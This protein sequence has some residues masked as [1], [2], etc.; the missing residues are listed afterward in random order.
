MNSALAAVLSPTD[1]VA[2]AAIT[3]RVA[4]PRRIL[5]VL[6]GESLLNDASGL[7]CFQFAVAAALTGSLMGA[8]LQ[9]PAVLIAVAAVLIV[10]ATSLFGLWELRL[11]GGL[12]QAAAKSYSGYFGSLF[13]G[14]T[15]G[16]VAAPCIG[17]FVL[18]L[19]FL[20][21]E[22]TGHHLHGDD[23]DVAELADVARHG[24]G[25]SLQRW[26]GADT[27]VTTL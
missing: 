19:G 22:T 26:P 27:E 21:A 11:P 3:E 10:F 14:L 15:L 13:M 6:E 17:P 2:V 24:R 16:V 7:V 25:A 23:A 20:R 9:H 8:V 5:H 1:P 4:V 18:G 12:T